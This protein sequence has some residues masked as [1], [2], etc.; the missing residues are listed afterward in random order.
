MRRHLHC[1]LALSL[2]CACAAPR[3][4]LYPNERYE[5]AGKDQ[6][7]ADID[8]CDAKAKE[9]V[10]ANKGKLVAKKT[11]VGAAFGAFI[12]M[13]FGAFSGNYRRAITEGAAVG[14]AAGLAHG[15]ADANSP[16]AVHKRFVEL[17]LSQKGYQPIGWK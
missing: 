11:G 5:V 17:C 13:I 16:D 7:K 12:G 3:P 14:A 15:A 10:K 9:F 4:V 6:V 2:L 8:D 1:L